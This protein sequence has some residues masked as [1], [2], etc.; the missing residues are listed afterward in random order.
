MY[1]ISNRS[2]RTY[3]KDFKNSPLAQVVAQQRHHHTHRRRSNSCCNM[4]GCNYCSSRIGSWGT[5]HRCCSSRRPAYYNTA[6]GSSWSSRAGNTR[7]SVAA[8][9]SS[10]RVLARRSKGPPFWQ[11]PPPMWGTRWEVPTLQKSWEGTPSK[12]PTEL[13]PD[14][15]IK[16]YR[17]KY[18]KN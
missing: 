10:S 8:P 3:L 18:R 15:K 17:L 9:C 7:R 5:T 13:Q 1:K 11:E 12:M 2:F 4:G 6:F 16:Y 14:F